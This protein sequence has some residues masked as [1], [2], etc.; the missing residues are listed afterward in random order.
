M[1]INMFAMDDRTA[2]IEF[3]EHRYFGSVTA[4]DVD[5][6]L[7]CFDDNADIVIRHGDLP[8]RR[9]SPSPR[10]GQDK[11]LSFYQHLCANYNCWF[12]DFHHTIDIDEQLA[13]SRFTVR[14][15]PKANG[16]YAAFPEQ[17]LLNC[18]FFEFA[19][20]RIKFMLIYYSNRT[21]GSADKP[22]GYPKP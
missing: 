7:D 10:H 22:T 5:G 18:N 6:V 19:D 8:E 17:Q 21:E 11:L 13:A 3:I 12:G 9:F 15:N 1:L 2:Y 14:L 16:L 20:S 4:G